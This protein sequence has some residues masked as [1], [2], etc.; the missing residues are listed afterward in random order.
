LGNIA[1][2]VFDYPLNE[3]AGIWWTEGGT[4]GLDLPSYLM[5]KDNQFRGGK[6][7]SRDS[8]LSGKPKEFKRWFHRKWKQPGSPDATYE[9]IL[10][11]YKE[12]IR[13]GKP[14]G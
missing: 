1:P 11:A 7:G 9:E 10:D 6:K 8:E 2:H 5:A 14:K 3:E 4:T 12:W 13:L